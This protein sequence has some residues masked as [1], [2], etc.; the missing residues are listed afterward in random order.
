MVV[1]WKILSLIDLVLNYIVNDFFWLQEYF[2]CGYNLVNFL[3][4]KLVFLVDWIL[5]YFSLDIGDGKYEVKGIFDIIDK[6][7]YLEVMYWILY[8]I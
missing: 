6:M 7:E 4:F 1:N 5:L 2:E 8:V 3:Y